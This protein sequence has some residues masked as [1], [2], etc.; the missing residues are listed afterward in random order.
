MDID[1]T[2]V[3]KWVVK[4]NPF[5]S[6]SSDLGT[7]CAICLKSVYK[8]C[9][10]SIHSKETMIR[11]V[12][13]LEWIYMFLLLCKKRKDSLFSLLD[14]NVLTRIFKWCLTGIQIG[15]KCTVAELECGHLSHRCC[16]VMWCMTKVFSCFVCDK[17]VSIVPV[18]IYGKERVLNS[19]T[20][21]S[22]WTVP[23]YVPEY[24]LQARPIQDDN[25]NRRVVKSSEVDPGIV[26]LGIYN[27]VR[28]YDGEF[29]KQGLYTFI[30]QMLQHRV[31]KVAFDIGFDHFIK[32]GN[33]YV[34]DTTNKIFIKKKL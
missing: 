25:N 21:V 32:Q 11:T 7:G 28:L 2:T 10:Y 19:G 30:C 34:D 17:R 9:E 33:I 24:K 15:T 23:K 14:M 16:L 5:V 1:T 27:S 6:S 29:D 26:Y 31:D 4:L 12:A 13:S 18:S 22:Q 3:R 8:Y 20:L